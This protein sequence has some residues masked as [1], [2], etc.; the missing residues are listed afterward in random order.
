[1][2]GYFGANTINQLVK[3]L[4]KPRLF[5]H[6]GLEAPCGAV[7]QPIGGLATPVTRWIFPLLQHLGDAGAVDDAPPEHGHDELVGAVVRERRTLVALEHHIL[8]DALLLQWLDNL[9][10]QAGELSLRA[11]GVLAGNHH[12]A[13]ERRVVANERR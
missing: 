1:M 2:S 3:S 4:G 11:G 9:G 8:P 13:D 6:L 7:E 12:V 10:N 5:D